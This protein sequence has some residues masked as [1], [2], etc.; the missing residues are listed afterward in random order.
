MAQDLDE[1]L[2]GVDASFYDRMARSVIET[3]VNDE[4][5]DR[6]WR[7]DMSS[8]SRLLWHHG[9]ETLVMMLGAYVQA[10]GAAHAYFLKCRTDDARKLAE[11]FLKEKRPVQNRITDAPFTIP[12]LLKGVHLHTGWS[13]LDETVERFGIA[14]KGM[15]RSFSSEEHRWEYNSIKHG[16]RAHHGEFALAFGIQEAPGI[17]APDEA[18]EMLGYSKDASFFNITKSLRN[19][20]NQASRV[21]FALDKVTVTW[22]LEK[23]LCDLQ[24]ISLLIG[25]IISSLRII[26]GATPKTVIFQRPADADNWWKQYYA[27]D[28]SSIPT[29]RFGPEL[30]AKGK[31]LPTGDDVL[32]SYRK[33]EWGWP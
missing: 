26:A 12:N 1:F 30:D 22:S 3:P 16:L 2:T 25:N 4:N 24:I 33:R 31:K 14:L 17:P 10:P 27:L 11:S 21:N 20:T 13:N 29:A 28:T 9:I 8:V 7:K 6:Q 19:A 32:T 23:V 18:M 5:Q 15:L